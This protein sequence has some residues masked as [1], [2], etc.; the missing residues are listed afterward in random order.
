MSDNMNLHNLLH[1]CHCNKLS[2]CLYMN[3]HSYIDNFLDNFLNKY[4]NKFP[5]IQSNNR[6]ESCYLSGLNFHFL[7]Q[8]LVRLP[9]ELHP[10]LEEHLLLP[11]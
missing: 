3:H 1:S 10:K 6:L 8:Y 5:Y 7:L 9:S 4:R 2:K 11:S